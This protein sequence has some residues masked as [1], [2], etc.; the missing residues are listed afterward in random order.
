M[1]SVPA[2][3]SASA[4]KGNLN[5]AFMLTPTLPGYGEGY[6]PSAHCGKNLLPVVCMDHC[7]L[8]Q[9]LSQAVSAVLWSDT[10]RPTLRPFGA[11]KA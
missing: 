7:L 10:V 4:L 8:Q 2:F 11:G 3:S 1:S 9:T 5:S 6:Q